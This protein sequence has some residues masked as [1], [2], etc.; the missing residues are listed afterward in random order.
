MVRRRFGCDHQ[1]F[2][3]HAADRAVARSILPDLRM[4]R[5]GVD[6]AFFLRGCRLGRRGQVAGGGGDEFFAASR[7]AEVERAAVVL[8][9]M[10]GGLRI[11]LHAANRIG[12]AWIV[13]G[14]CR[15]PG[16]ASRRGMRAVCVMG[17]GVRHDTT[18]RWPPRWRSGQV[19]GNMA[20]S[21]YP[22]WVW[23]QGRANNARRDE[24]RHRH[25]AEADRRAGWWLAADGG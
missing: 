25:A 14:W 16:G 19:T 1:R 10:L 12:H 4:H 21:I 18:P 8:Q 17:F 13:G 3:R 24:S 15:V 6:R 5:A 22:S 23:Y 9:A 7:R 11:N 20:C 2:E